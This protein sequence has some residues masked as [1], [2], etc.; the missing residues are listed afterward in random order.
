VHFIRGRLPEALK[1][2]RVSLSLDKNNVRVMK[3]LA[4][5]FG[6]MGRQQ[7]ALQMWLQIRSLNPQDPDLLRVFHAN[8]P[9]GRPS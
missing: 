6:R 1:D 8:P 7:E 2:Y 9:P 3:N 5:V 4:S